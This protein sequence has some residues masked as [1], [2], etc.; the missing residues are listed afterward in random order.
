MGV[1]RERGRGE[2]ERER[3][4]GGGEKDRHTYGKSDRQTKRV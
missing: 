1:R 3:G 4:G 2:R